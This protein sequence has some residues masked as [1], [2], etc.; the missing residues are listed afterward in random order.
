M[1][2]QDGFISVGRVAEF[3]DS[4]GNPIVVNGRELALF[5]HHDQ[6]SAIDAICPH[7]GGPLSAGWCEQGTV[8]CPLHG[9]RFDLLTGQCLEREDKKVA[10]HTVRLVGENIQVRLNIQPI[11]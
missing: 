10:V 2:S 3:D 5:F 11:Q 1:N 8:A 9:W 4:H 6:W 7:R